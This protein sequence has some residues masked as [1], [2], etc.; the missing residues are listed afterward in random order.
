M[1][2]ATKKKIEQRAYEIFV[3]RGSKP[4][5]SKTDWDQAEKE[6]LAEMSAPKLSQVIKESP[7][8]KPAQS[9][10]QPAQVKKPQQQQQQRKR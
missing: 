1:N 4:G 7:V 10:Q 3:K 5:N 2:E 9:A 6:I 8:E